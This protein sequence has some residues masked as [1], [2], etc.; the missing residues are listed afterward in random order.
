MSIINIGILAHVDAGKTSLTER[1]LY[2]GGS[3]DRLGFVDSGNTQTDSMALE[4]ARGITIKSA[5]AS[6]VFNHVTINILDTP[7]HPDFIAE[8]ERVLSI[9]DGVLLVISA[10]EGIQPQTRILLRAIKRLQ[11]PCII[12]INKVDRM[13]ARADALVD[14]IKKSL[15]VQPLV[16]SKVTSLGSNSADV[17]ERSF[18]DELFRT[19]VYEALAEVDD[20]IL[21]CYVRAEPIGIRNLKAKILENVVDA[22]L[23]LVYFGSAITGVGVDGLMKA[24]VNFFMQKNK[25]VDDELAGQI[26]KIERDNVGRKHAYIRL[27]QGTLALRDDVHYGVVKHKSKKNRITAIAVLQQSHWQSQQSLRKGEIG[28]ILGLEDAQ[29]GDL[30]GDFKQQA[31]KFSPPILESLIKAK[32]AADKHLLFRALKQLAEQ[33]PLINLRQI[34][35]QISISL[36]GEVQK[37]VIQATLKQQFGVDVLFERSKP[38]CIERVFAS[39]QAVASIK[40]RNNPFLATIGLRIEP[41]VINSGIIFQL[42]VELGSIPLA[43]HRV[44]EE[45]VFSALEEGLFAW[46]V[47]DCIVT[48]T[49][50]GY[51]PRQSRSHAVFDKSMSSKGSDF[52][53]LTPLVLFDALKRAGTEVCQPVHDFV[54][55]LPTPTC[56]AVLAHLNQ[57]QVKPLSQQSTSAVITRIEGEIVAAD[58]HACCQALPDLTHGEGVFE[59]SFKRF[60]AISGQSPIR[61]RMGLNPLDRDQYLL[62][63]MKTGVVMKRFR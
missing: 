15:K 36:Y 29:I 47:T 3:I 18:D 63:M 50:S 24:I 42:E 19:D 16:M 6:L 54:L 2:Q 32:S 30:I 40:D 31:F 12:F 13:G 52:R 23:S 9:L 14:E 21:A 10:V 33:D 60:E 17:L 51:F 39:G 62:E 25:G 37:D 45:T 27:F 38:L 59:S 26:F 22:K 55:D 44:L 35:E 46:P 7:G 48:L 34:N 56:S 11:L 49:H 57:F 5:V 20:E 4:K 1:L 43:F 28:R 61:Q 53:Y 41:G 8:V 58:I